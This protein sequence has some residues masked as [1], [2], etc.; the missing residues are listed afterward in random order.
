M[1]YSEQYRNAVEGHFSSDR[2]LG[3]QASPDKV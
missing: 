1:A 2:D 3:Y